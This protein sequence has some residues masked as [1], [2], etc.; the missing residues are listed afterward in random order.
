[1]RAPAKCG[2][3]DDD[4]P[5]LQQRVALQQGLAAYAGCRVRADAVTEHGHQ[6]SRRRQGLV[7]ARRD[8]VEVAAQLERPQQQRCVV[9]G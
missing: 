6:E 1:M 8:G 3:D 5:L 9:A 7:A 2:G 4:R